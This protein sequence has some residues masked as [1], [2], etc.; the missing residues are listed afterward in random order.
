[1]SL[2]PET[3]LSSV[4]LVYSNETLSNGRM[5][6]TSTVIANRAMKSLFVV[7]RKSTIE[8]ELDTSV[9]EASAVVAQQHSLFSRE[10][11]TC[12]NRGKQVSRMATDANNG[13]QEMEKNENCGK[14]LWKV[15]I[16]HLESTR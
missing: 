10:K 4:H 11:R 7:S 8:D 5:I 2:L 3:M 13:Q 14:E 16:G 6:I 9:Q 1:M 12:T 15:G